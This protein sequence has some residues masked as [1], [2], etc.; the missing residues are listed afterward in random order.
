MLNRTYTGG[1]PQKL[2]LLSQL[3]LFNLLGINAPL[4][5]TYLNQDHVTHIISKQAYLVG[6]YAV[7]GTAGR[8]HQ[9]TNLE[10]GLIYIMEHS[11]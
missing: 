9:E 8:V 1:N 4:G 10:F 11:H 7:K 6:Q 2:A 5:L 3:N